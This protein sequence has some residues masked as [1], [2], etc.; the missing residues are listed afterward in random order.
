VLRRP[1][2]KKPARSG[3]IP[4]LYTREISSFLKTLVAKQAKATSLLGVASRSPAKCSPT[5]VL[6]PRISH[7]DPL[8]PFVE[9]EVVRIVSLQREGDAFFT[10]VLVTLAP[11]RR[12]RRSEWV[13]TS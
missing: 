13:C 1:R 3:K 11:A 6:E 2:G 4:R 8:S 7:A 9:L 10:T 5:S 12:L